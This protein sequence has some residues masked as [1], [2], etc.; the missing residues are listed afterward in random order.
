LVQPSNRRD[1]RLVV[2]IVDRKQPTSALSGTTID[3]HGQPA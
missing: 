2:E 1:A 3:E